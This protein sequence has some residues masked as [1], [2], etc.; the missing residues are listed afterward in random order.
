MPSPAALV[1]SSVPAGRVV[2]PDLFIRPAHDG[3]LD[4]APGRRT[5][6]YKEAEGVCLIHE[7]FRYAL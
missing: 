6:N 7:F 4:V 5:Y 3:V 1:T 2:V